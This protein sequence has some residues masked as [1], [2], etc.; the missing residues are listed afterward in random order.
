M[1]RTVLPDVCVL[2]FG[3][4]EMDGNELARQP[5]AHPE[6]AKT[7]LI[8]LTGYGQAHD[9]D[10]AMAAGFD[11][12]MTKPVELQKLLDTLAAFHPPS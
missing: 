12:H 8:A 4:P 2:D 11:H 3:L 9:F 7:L 1:A 5:R 6:T 10:E